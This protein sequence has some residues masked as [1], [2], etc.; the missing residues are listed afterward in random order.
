MTLKEIVELQSIIDKRKIA[1]DTLNTLENNYYFSKSK[2]QNIKFADMH[3]DHFLRALKLDKQN[4]SQ[5]DIQT[6]EVIDQLKKTL[7]K[8]KRLAGE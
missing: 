5:V 7:T 1:K 2:N 4:K 8:I 6:A 3:I